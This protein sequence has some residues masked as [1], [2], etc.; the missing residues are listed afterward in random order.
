MR[1]INTNIFIHIYIYIYI[2]IYIFYRFARTY[3]DTL[4]FV[5]DVYV[6]KKHKGN[7]MHNPDAI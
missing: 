5:P 6:C 3:L 2:Y 1:K 7:R 4:Y